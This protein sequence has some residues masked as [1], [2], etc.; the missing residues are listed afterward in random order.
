MEGGRQTIV[1]SIVNQPIFEYCMEGERKHGSSPHQLWWE[2]P[3]D[4][5]AA[6]AEAMASSIVAAGDGSLVDP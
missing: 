3:M 1:Q 5:D 2:Q 4:L 6:R